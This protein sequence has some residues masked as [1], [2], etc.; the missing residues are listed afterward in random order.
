M[1]DPSAANAGPRCEVEIYPGTDCPR[2][3]LPGRAR[4]RQHLEP[5]HEAEAGRGEAPR[6]DGTATHSAVQG[7]S[8]DWVERHHNVAISAAT[9]IVL[10]VGYLSQH[11][12]L[13]PFGIDVTGYAK[14]PD[15]FTFAA[16]NL[17][18]AAVLMIRLLLIAVLILA[19]ALVFF[20][21]SVLFEQVVL[22]Q[23]AIALGRRHG[24]NP[25]RFL[26][27]NA[28]YSL[29][30][31]GP[32]KAL[33]RWL[34]AAAFR[35]SGAAPG[36][37]ANAERLR[38]CREEF[39]KLGASGAALWNEAPGLPGSVRQSRRAVMLLLDAAVGKVAGLFRDRFVSAAIVLVLS[40]ATASA[41]LNFVSAHL[42][43]ECARD[44]SPPAAQ[45]VSGWHC[46]GPRAA[47]F[48]PEALEQRVVDLLKWVVGIKFAP[49]VQVQLGNTY[50]TVRASVRGG[51]VDRLVH[52][53]NAGGATFFFNLEE[54]RPQV[55]PTGSITSINYYSDV[56]ARKSPRLTVDVEARTLEDRLA[57]VIAKLPSGVSGDGATVAAIAKL[58]ESLAG[59]SATLDEIRESLSALKPPAVPSP[60]R[61]EIDDAVQMRRG[62]EE[63][64]DRA[65]LAL[66]DLAQ[67]VRAGGAEQRLAMEAAVSVLARMAL[68][69]EKG[70]PVPVLTPPTNPAWTRADGTLT[71]HLPGMP[72]GCRDALDGA[73]IPFETRSASLLDG[74][75]EARTRRRMLLDG[76]GALLG[77][78]SLVDGG[79]RFV[80]VEA[81]AGRD[82]ESAGTPAL[83]SARAEAV[84][85]DLE[86]SLVKAGAAPLRIVSISRPSGLVNRG[87]SMPRAAA[88]RRVHVY[89]CPWSVA[90]ALLG[91][92][93]AAAG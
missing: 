59:T 78:P 42:M 91:D 80:V 62:V 20:G 33:A 36:E 61:V 65:L 79:P 18:D 1:T 90:P 82:E 88:T 16:V 11:M 6:A 73:F 56:A 31:R 43:R 93:L 14:I 37:P 23:R 35:R 40:M 21:G 58:G 45:S 25:I 29:P 32:L 13:A 30:E 34:A 66:A 84:R 57:G 12:F 2:P 38:E 83:A 41:L 4:C 5:E 24:V 75:R 19:I 72:A 74:S 60:L 54:D 81:F 27:I 39:E 71:A 8:F 28:L 50:D 86:A 67:A 53:G 70:V 10:C 68:Q 76:A 17:F 51:S 69:L 77:R 49:I 85:R 52:L 22:V 87:S 7:W 47:L 26:L 63:R 44:G 89:H 48:G 55:V 46:P 9:V 3:A 64:L 92:A 15:L